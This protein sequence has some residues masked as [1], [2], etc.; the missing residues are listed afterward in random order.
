MYF[1]KTDKEG[2]IDRLKIR[3]PSF[4]N[5]QAIQWAVLGDIVADF[6]LVNKSLNFSYAGTDL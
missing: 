5:W 3:D 1:V 6:P 4:N 2:K